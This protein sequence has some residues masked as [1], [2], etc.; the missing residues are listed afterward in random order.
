MLRLEFVICIIVFISSSRSNSS[1]SNCNDI[2]THNWF[3]LFSDS[4]QMLE[5]K[6]CNVKNVHTAAPAFLCV[7]LS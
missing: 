4:E 3:S 1:S 6:C 5:I 7:S 2:T